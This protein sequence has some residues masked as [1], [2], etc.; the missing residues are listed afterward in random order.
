M[1]VKENRIGAWGATSDRQS[2]ITN[3]ILQFDGILIMIEQLIEL[4]L[5]LDILI[6]H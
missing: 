1:V 6:K 5:G 3:Y 2:I 4:D